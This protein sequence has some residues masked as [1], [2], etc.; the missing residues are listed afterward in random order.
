MDMG[1][2]N[3]NISPIS[4]YLD[5]IILILKIF[6]YICT[7]IIKSVLEIFISVC[8]LFKGEGRKQPK[9]S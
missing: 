1:I 6:L 3:R 9:L 5:N 2:E 4:Q 8:V 7:Y